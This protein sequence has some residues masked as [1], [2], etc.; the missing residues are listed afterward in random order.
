M[1][2]LGFIDED[3]GTRLELREGPY[4]TETEVIAHEF[5]MQWFTKLDAFLAG[6]TERH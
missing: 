3:G 2:S 6:Q 5:W 4:S 1:S